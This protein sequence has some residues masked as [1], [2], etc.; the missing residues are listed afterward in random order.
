M[1]SE[2][3]SVGYG[4]NESWNRSKKQGCLFL[5]ELKRLGFKLQKILGRVLSGY[6]NYYYY[7]NK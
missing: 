4:S 1:I 7:L 2:I 6:K 3:T 5:I